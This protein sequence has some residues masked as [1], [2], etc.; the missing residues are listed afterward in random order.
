MADIDINVTL[1]FD[2]AETAHEFPTVEAVTQI[3]HA[4]DSA[5]FSA[6]LG[7]TRTTAF[8]GEADLRSAVAVIAEL[9][10]E[11]GRAVPPDIVLGGIT[12]PGEPWSPQQLIDRIGRYREHGVA[13]VAVTVAGRTRNE[14]CD[15]AAR[16]GADVIAHL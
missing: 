14:W 9:C 11:L 4:L 3:G 12:R 5:G 8:T 10:E 1:P 6:G 15:N 2:D 16:I 7:T 13:A